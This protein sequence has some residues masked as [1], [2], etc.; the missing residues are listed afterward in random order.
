MNSFPVFENK[1]DELIEKIRRGDVDEI[2]EITPKDLTECETNALFMAM[3]VSYYSWVLSIHCRQI[4]FVLTIFF[5]SFFFRFCR[6][7]C[8]FFLLV[9]KCVHEN[10]SNGTR[11]FKEN[12][13]NPN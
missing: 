6:L 10:V 2:S 9:Y 1:E 5:F 11:V 12:C 3:K 13:L 4:S 8:F 7:L